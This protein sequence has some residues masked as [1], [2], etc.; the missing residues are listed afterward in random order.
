MRRV[1]FNFILLL[2]TLL[3]RQSSQ[4]ATCDA[5]CLDG[6]KCKC[7]GT[8]DAESDKIV[9]CH[10][11][12]CTGT[13]ARCSA[14][15][16]TS[17]ANCENGVPCE[18]LPGKSEDCKKS[19]VINWA[20]F[21]ATTDSNGLI[22]ISSLKTEATNSKAFAS[23]ELKNNIEEEQS[24]QFKIFSGD[25]SEKSSNAYEASTVI[26][27]FNFDVGFK[28]TRHKTII[29]NKQLELNFTGKVLANC[30]VSSS[31]RIQDCNFLY[32]TEKIT[33]QHELER[34]IAGSLKV[35]TEDFS[36]EF[37]SIFV[38]DINDGYLSGMINS[39]SYVLN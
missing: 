12:T 15:G 6:T 39:S 3:T 25:L 10:D 38:L 14:G 5:S 1:F 17:K 36:S 27:L 18:E 7:T 31:G 20:V 26:H 23:K 34:A 37:Y 21:S 32:S 30:R 33:N 4:A 8:C 9:I 11:G 29:L 13:P 16:T 22:E 28:Q 19:G 2:G 24:A 35:F